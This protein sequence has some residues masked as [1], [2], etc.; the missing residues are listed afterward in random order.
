MYKVYDLSMPLDR[1]TPVFPG[2]PEP[3]FSTTKVTI[4]MHLGTHIDA[5][6][7]MIP[8]GKKLSDFP[9]RT[10]VGSATV[11]DVRG[12]KQI[13]PD[14][15]AVRKN[16]IVFLLTGHSDKARSKD[17]FTKYPVLTPAAAKEVIRRKVKIIGIDSFTPDSP[18]Y[19]IHKMLL[20]HDILIVENLV[21]LAPLAGR[22]FQCVIAPLNLQNTDAAPCRI[23]GILDIKIG[24]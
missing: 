4:G 14:L 2:D 20:K 17:Y 10:F 23:F 22:R 12:Q 8:K 1:K 5:P 19:E 7:H 6:Y 16:D 9:T 11:I 15:K 24:K 21:G 18:P 13:N 3:E